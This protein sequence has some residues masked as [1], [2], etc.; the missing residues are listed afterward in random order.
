MCEYLLK[1]VKPSTTDEYYRIDTRFASHTLSDREQDAAQNAVQT[2]KHVSIQLLPNH[3]LSDDNELNGFLFTCGA[4]E[5]S[6]CMPFNKNMCELTSVYE[7][8]SHSQDS[9]INEDVFRIAGDITTYREGFSELIKHMQEDGTNT[10]NLDCIVESSGVENNSIFLND[11][12]EDRSWKEEMPYKMGIYHAMVHSHRRSENQHRIYIVVSGVLREA[13]EAIYN[14]WFDHGAHLTCKQFIESEELNWLRQTTRRN[15]NRIAS[16]LADTFCLKMPRLIDETDP[17][18]R[19]M[20][21]PTVQTFL[22]NAR[23]MDQTAE[24]VNCGHFVDDTNNGLVM[25]IF[26]VEGFWLFMGPPDKTNCNSYGDVFCYRD[27]VK[28]LPTKTIRFNECYKPNKEVRAVAINHSKKLNNVIYSQC[29]NVRTYQYPDERFITA[30]QRMGFDRN[31][32]VV[33][34]MPL[35]VYVNED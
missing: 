33:H 17:N 4:D 5:P 28:A 12:K 1:Q 13:S 30:M 10:A 32:G 9:L 29:E 6:N 2:S 19:R 22:H 15:H 27:G 11:M 20:C 34:L 3:H 14:L 8:P 26:G 31:D 23:I 21:L 25:D 16:L 18:R 35:L 24:L 7:C